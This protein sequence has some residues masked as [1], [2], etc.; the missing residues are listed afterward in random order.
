MERQLADLAAEVTRLK[1]HED[2]R[3]AI[4]AY[5]RGIDRG[6]A[7]LLDP[8]FHEDAEDDH[9][10][11]R[12]TKHDALAAF[13]KSAKNPAVSSSVHHIGNI[14]IDLRGDVADVE[15]YFMASQRREEDGK[16]WIRMRVGR[17]LDRFEKRDG[18]WR[19]ARRKVIDDWSSLDELA[20]PARE[21]G[22]DNNHGT[23]GA[24]DPSRA[25]T[26]FADHHRHPEAR[27]RADASNS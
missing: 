27:H 1:D 9:G 15:T 26:G 14:L 16:H 11:F 25:V 23:R 21:V 22:P 6:D 20:Q 12:G 5:A 19:V 10:N 18:I 7:T 8:A 24:D 3:Q 17:Y 2:I 4:Y 13:A